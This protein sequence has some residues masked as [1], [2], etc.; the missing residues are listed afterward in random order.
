VV[1]EDSLN[2][3]R[4]AKAAGMMVIAVPNRVTQRLDFR[5]AHL[6]VSSLDAVSLRG[7]PLLSA[8]ETHA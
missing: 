8:M 2:G 6:Q 1:F 7:L 4:A 5:E 3:V